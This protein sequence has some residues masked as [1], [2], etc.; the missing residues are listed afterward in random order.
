MKVA[1]FVLMVALA[2]A[3]PIRAEPTQDDM[4]EGLGLL[5][6]GAQMLLRGLLSE[7]EPALEEMGKS[8]AELEPLLR[9]LAG[10][11]GSVS[12]YHMPEVL[13]NGDI[14]IRR[15]QPADLPQ[16]PEGGI[17]L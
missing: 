17:D 9:D 8:L 1:P 7:M 13:P 4:S 3:A 10:K 5:G 15:K 6:K 12:E 14:I 16:V 11:M 2:L